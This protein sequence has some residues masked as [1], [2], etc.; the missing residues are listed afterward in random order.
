MI[1]P[2]NSVRFS[3]R[4]PLRLL[5]VSTLAC[6]P[7]KGFST[8]SCSTNSS[9]I[10]DLDPKRVDL[11]AKVGGRI[12]PLD[13][14]GAAVYG[15]DL[16]MAPPSGQVLQALEEEMANRGF[17]VF[18]D[19]DPNMTV[20]QELAATCW[21]G[22]Q[23]LH[24]THGVHP[25]TPDYNR[26]IFRL[27]NDRKHG[28]LGVGPQWH[29]DGSFVSGTFSHVGYRIIQPPNV[30]GTHFCHQ[31]AAFDS[32]PPERQEFW[33]R[34]SSVNSNGGVVHPAVHVHPISK[35]KSVW[36][37]LGMTGAVIE[38]K[39]D[40]DGFRLLDYDEMKTLFN[41]YNDLLNAGMKKSQDGGYTVAYEYKKGDFLFIDNLAVA[42]RASPEAHMPPSKVGL[43][44]MHRTTIGALRD[45]EPHFGLPQYMEI[46]GPSPFGQ[47][48]W[49]GGGIGFRFDESL[50]F[51][52]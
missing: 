27:S 36:L 23:Q 30:G 12:E 31:G 33:E 42:H 35:R 21:W 44:I 6:S 16:T 2:R 49:Q 17:L 20:E 24:S 43:R 5:T 8:T 4:V 40:E 34:L 47:G 14:I 41:E 52:N 37:H 29:N 3:W 38:R 7:S 26:H 48:I 28:I 45:F 25:A 15:I 10:P 13:P 22:S 50:H 11:V 46:D 32:L 1:L 9:M 39:K 19:Q 51:Q 18:K